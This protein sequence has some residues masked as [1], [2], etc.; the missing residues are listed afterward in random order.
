MNFPESW[1]VMWALVFAIFCGCKWLTWR[2]GR[3]AGAPAWRTFS[4]LFLWPGLDA[5]AFL[6]EH[7]SPAR[8]SIASWAAAVLKILLGALLL[9]VFAPI[10]PASQLL[11]KGWIGMTGLILLLHFGAFHLLALG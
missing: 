4:Y 1:V 2:H 5:R 9:W 8:P 6:D 3:V 7:N 11:L 10:V